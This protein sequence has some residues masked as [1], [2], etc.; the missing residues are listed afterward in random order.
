MA[1]N[2]NTE[3]HK[4]MYAYVYITY[5]YFA[6]VCGKGISYNY[7]RNSGEHSE[8]YRFKKKHIS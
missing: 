5:T 6:V 1:A 8:P 7:I 4:K 3:R 2:T